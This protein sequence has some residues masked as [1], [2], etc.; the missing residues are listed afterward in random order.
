VV[1]LSKQIEEKL[2]KECK[3]QR[4]KDKKDKAAKEAQQ[5]AKGVASVISAELELNGRR[6]VVMEA[7]TKDDATNP[8]NLTDDKKKQDKRNLALKRE[9]LLNFE[10]WI[11]KNPRPNEKAMQQ[12]QRLQD[13][14]DKALSKSTNLFVSRKRVQ[15]RNLPKRD[16]FEKELKELM[17]VVIEEWIKSTSESGTQTST[18]SQRK[19]LLK[20]VK[21]LRDEQKTDGATGEKLASGLGFA[22]FDD[23]KLTLFAIRYLNNM[24]L[25]GQGRG[26]VVDFSL[27]DAR[28][29]HE[30]EKR[31]EKIK[32]LQE[33][34][35]KE[36]KRNGKQEKAQ[37]PVIG[38]VVEL[39]KKGQAQQ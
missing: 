28:A 16:F 4:I 37:E 39:G 11:H 30:R 29:L 34:K 2:D 19:K 7:M 33:D 13:E 23:E 8:K 9:G 27:E 38:G 6:L 5:A 26:L 12:R 14:K 15:L 22:E 21:V 18:K 17:L 32:K 20:Q 35:K 25:T 24:E 31:M 10:D 36:Q 1:K 3:D